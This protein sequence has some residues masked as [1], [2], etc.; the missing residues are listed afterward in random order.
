MTD[1]VVFEVVGKFTSGCDTSES[2]RDVTSDND[3]EEEDEEEEELDAEEQ[4]YDD[5]N[6]EAD[7]AS[8]HVGSG[9][10]E[11]ASPA[12]AAIPTYPPMPAGVRI[13]AKWLPHW[14]RQSIA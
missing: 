9:N 11:G 2:E 4:L 13:Q 5:L 8:P 3:D 12:S 6:E 1:A 10:E 14:R 7:G